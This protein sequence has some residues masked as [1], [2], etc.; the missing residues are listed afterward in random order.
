MADTSVSRIFNLCAANGIYSDR[1]RDTRRAGRILPCCEPAPFDFP[2]AALFTNWSRC[3]V[4]WFFVCDLDLQ[5]RTRTIPEP[6]RSL[7]LACMVCRLRAEPF[8]TWLPIGFLPPVHWDSMACPAT[9]P[10]QFEVARSDFCA[11]RSDEAAAPADP[12][13]VFRLADERVS[14]IH[15]RA[16]ISV[17]LLLMSFAIIAPSIV[18]MMAPGRV[19]PFSAVASS[20]SRHLVVDILASLFE[21]RDN[22]ISTDIF[23]LG[24][25]NVARGVG[26]GIV[27]VTLDGEGRRARRQ[28]NHPC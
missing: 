28:E 8:G 17:S 27:S 20:R 22:R 12:T 2:C 3:E 6:R 24:V 13:A 14:R 10:V 4:D 19:L 5:S 18:D 25:F 7:L 26:I 11:A 21:D 15:P 1:N 9:R 16:H 23:R